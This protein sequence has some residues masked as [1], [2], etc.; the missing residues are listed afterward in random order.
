[1]RRI[2]I[3]LEEAN[4]MNGLV[5]TRFKMYIGNYELQQTKNGIHNK[6]DMEIIKNRDVEIINYEI[7]KK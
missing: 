5:W 1:M 6:K 7:M 4:N 2:E 3:S